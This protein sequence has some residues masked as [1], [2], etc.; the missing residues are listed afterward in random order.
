MLIQ[1]PIYA[2]TSAVI[3]TVENGS[4]ATVASYLGD[5]FIQLGG[6]Q[7]LPIVVGVYSIVMGLFIPA[8]GAR[9]VLEAPYVFHAA[10]AGGF[11]LGWI[12]MVFNG[13]ETLTNFINPF[14][15]LPLLGM[16]CLKPKNVIGHT[17]I[18]FI[19]LAPVMLITLWLLSFS[20]SYIPPVFP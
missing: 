8:A 20:L 7:M 2:A 13:S 11:N 18:Y 1:F 14:W 12:L 16:L 15:M 3:V 4:G 19:F 10:Q 9:W 6:G 5:F 17:F